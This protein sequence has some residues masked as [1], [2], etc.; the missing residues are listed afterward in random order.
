M[1]TTRG[2][3]WI[4]VAALG[5]DFAPE[6]E[7]QGD[8]IDDA[9]VLP[10]KADGLDGA[11]PDEIEAVIALANTADLGLLDVDVALDVRAAEAI[12]TRRDG[13]DGALGTAD[14][15]LFDDLAELDAVPWVGPR[16]FG[17]M[18]QWVRDHAPNA[19][20]PCVLISEYIEGKQDK[21]KFLELYNCGDTAV[22]LSEIAVCLV[23]NDDADCTLTSRLSPGEL[24]PG[25]VHTLCRT[26]TVQWQSPWPPLAEGCQE[27]LGST[28]IF[29][30]D[31]RVVVLHDP[32]GTESVHEAAV[33]DAL[34]R[35]AFRPSWSPWND[36]GLRRCTAQPNPGIAFFDEADWFETVPWSSADDWG[37]PPTFSCDP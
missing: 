15:D 16:A 25:E 29:S 26:T 4:C 32:E 35:I 27:E 18:L 20:A 19:A 23:R 9:I 1:G 31:D 8:G 11:S 3:A 34:G 30:G 5:C 10:G 14:D 24:A 33:L 13:P 6:P 37:V 36:V 17:K 28:M 2:V 7:P 12:V 21:N 22:D